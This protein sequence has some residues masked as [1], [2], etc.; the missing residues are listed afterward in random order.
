[1]E[2]FKKPTWDLINCTQDVFAMLCVDFPLPDAMDWKI[3]FFLNNQN[4][5]FVLT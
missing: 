5:H 2:L 4:C 1:M 3:F